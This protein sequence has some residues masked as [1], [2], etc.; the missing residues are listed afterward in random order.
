MTKTLWGTISPYKDKLLVKRYQLP[1][2]LGSIYLPEAFRGDRTQT[3][4]T[5]VEW[6][7]PEARKSLWEQGPVILDH[8]GDEVPISHE[9]QIPLQE[10]MIVQ[11]RAWSQ[12]DCDGT[13][14]FIEPHNVNALHT[15]EEED[16]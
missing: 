14:F 6:N 9:D 15:W 2:K 7:E 4:W 10:G 5:L 13:Y 11:T 1:E 12:I 16:E 8:D 3:L